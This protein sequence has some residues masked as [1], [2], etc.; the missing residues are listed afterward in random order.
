[1]ETPGCA[2]VR[3]DSGIPA[4]LGL[5]RQQGRRDSNPRPTVLET[6]AVSHN[7]GGCGLREPGTSPVARPAV[8]ELRNGLLTVKPSPQ[9][10][11]DGLLPRSHRSEE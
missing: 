2:A 6:R 4:C 3:M 1:M 10:P 9:L 11:E 5:F 8:G 7:R